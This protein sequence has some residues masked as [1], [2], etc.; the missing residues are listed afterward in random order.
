[1][2]INQ[3]ILTYFS[4]GVETL[5]GDCYEVFS[6]GKVLKTRVMREGFSDAQSIM[7]KKI[8]SSIEKSLNQN[9]A[10]AIVQKIADWINVNKDYSF[11]FEVLDGE[12]AH[13]QI[14]CD[15]HKTDY[16]AKSTRR[17]S[18][19]CIELNNLEKLFG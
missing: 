5:E 8:N 11:D 9:A 4:T 10:T 13:I 15:D 7:Y 6:S 19:H 12:L 1:M 16:L 18:T 3:P 17:F 14:S 2:P